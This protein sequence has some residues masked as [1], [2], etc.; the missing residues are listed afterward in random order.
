MR[1]KL[2]GWGSVQLP[3][4]SCLVGGGNRVRTPH[5]L[6]TLVLWESL[7]RFL[8][9]VG[10]ARAWSHTLSQGQDRNR[11]GCLSHSPCVKPAELT[12]ERGTPQP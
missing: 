12:Q 11:V 4:C 3:G 9:S 5:W 2:Q 10:P 8:F 7:S 1:L 6:R